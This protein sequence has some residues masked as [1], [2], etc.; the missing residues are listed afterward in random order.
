MS[1]TEDLDLIL[2]T[3]LPTD[4][5]FRQI[6]RAVIDNCISET[7]RYASEGSIEA[8]LMSAMRLL[9]LPQNGHT[10]LIPNDAIS[11]LPLRFVS[12]GRSVQVIGA[13]PGITAPRGKLIAVNGATLSQIEAIAEKFLAG[14][15]QRKR[16]IGPILLAWPYA[17]T[18]LGFSSNSGTT[19][20][21]VQGENGQITNLKVE[22]GN[23]VPGSM[24]YPRNEHG[25]ADPAWEPQTFV[26]FKDWQDLGLSIA[27]PSFFDP[28]ESALPKAISD[29]ADHVRA[30]SDK[31]LLIDVRGNTGGDF[32]LTMPLIDA[33]SQSASKQIVV[34]VDK[35][36]F[37]AAIVFVAILK[38]R[39]GNRLK[40]IGEEMGDGL[41]FFAEGGLLD[42]P[43]SGAV[44][45]YSSAF[46]DWKNG[47]SDETTP[48]DIAQQI[49]PAGELNL[50]RKWVARP[51]VEDAHG[52]FY[53][54]ILKGMNG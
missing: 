12:V 31:T 25:K 34:L 41:T 45:R 47:T 26:E 40:L 4:L 2:E 49:V 35:F 13:P 8:F 21:R 28:S 32:L 6:E 14:T 19:E 24:L 30:C 38:H 9:A 29:A 44:V 54:R 42:L 17:L 1:L 46:H 20:Y 51:A 15:C 50:D 22:N 36:T 18:R 37:S 39:L 53:Q 43:M 3:A 5:S 48:A 11:V 52:A 23:T 27:L 33:I 16:V 10:R 7:R